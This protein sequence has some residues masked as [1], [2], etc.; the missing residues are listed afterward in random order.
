[1]AN[2]AGHVQCAGVVGHVQCAGVAGHVQCAG[3]AGHVQCA[4]V[5]GLE[6]T[7]GDLHAVSAVRRAPGHVSP[8]QGDHLGL[9]GP[10][11]QHQQGH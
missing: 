11:A 4:G 6:G 9:P 10:H 7:R 3:V 5:R 2:I 1:M 8:V